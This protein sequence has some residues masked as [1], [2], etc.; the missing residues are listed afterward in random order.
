MITN[1]NAVQC[2]TFI[3]DNVNHLLKYVRANL[4]NNELCHLSSMCRVNAHSH[5]DSNNDRDNF[6]LELIR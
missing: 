5:A 3:N 6:G 1:T 2:D 4:M